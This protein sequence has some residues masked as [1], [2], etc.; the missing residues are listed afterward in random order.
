MPGSDG[1][2]PRLRQRRLDRQLDVPG[3]RRCRWFFARQRRVHILRGRSRD[4]G[5]A[6]EVSTFFIVPGG[7]VVDLL[8]GIEAGEEAV[9]GQLESVF[10]D[11]G[12]VGVVDEII[13]GDAVVGDGV[14]DHAAEE[15]DV[16]A[17]A[18]LHDTGRRWR[19][20]G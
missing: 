15:G 12:G 8:L 6:G 18:D 7:F 20:C 2:A 9:F 14:V 11:E 17:G 1:A 16:G 19:R 5:L 4:Y 3:R 10:D 13:F